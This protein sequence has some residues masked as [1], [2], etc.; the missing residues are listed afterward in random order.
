MLKSHEKFHSSNG[1]RL[2]LIADDEII[3]REILKE[4]LKDA[5]EIIEAAD[6]QEALDQMHEYKE[7]LSLVLLDLMMP[8]KTGY[9]VLESIKQD[10]S[11]SGSRDRHDIGSGTEVGDPAHRR[12]GLRPEALPAQGSHQGQDQRA[13][14]LSED[15]EIISVHGER[16]R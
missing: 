7:T 1:K 9:E 14:E 4:Q 2:L 16:S 10:P 11:I 3:N 5:Y 15:R 12:Y 8:K 13:I 6:G